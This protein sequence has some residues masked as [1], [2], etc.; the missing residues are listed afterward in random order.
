MTLKAL[1]RERL[2]SGQDVPSELFKPFEGNQTKNN[3]EKLE[4]SDA[5]TSKATK[6]DNLPS[7]GRYSK[8][9]RKWVLRK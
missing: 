1:V 2:E 3:K 4:M 6:K 8:Q 9:M 7:A 5:E